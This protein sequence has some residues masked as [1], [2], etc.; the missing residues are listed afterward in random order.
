[1]PESW[2]AI[3][4]AKDWISRLARQGAKIWGRRREELDRLFLEFGDYRFL[5]RAYIEPECQTGNP[6]DLQ[7]DENEPT[8]TWA[9][10]VPIR[11]WLNDF[12]TGEIRSRN[13]QNTLFVLS[14]AGMGKSSLL[15]MLKLTHLLKFWPDADDIAGARG[16]GSCSRASACCSPPPRVHR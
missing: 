15:V 12:L 1:M 14:D 6:A 8:P 4:L 2:I 10:R 13:G 7:Y 3:P 5:A 9:H 11:Q 16:T